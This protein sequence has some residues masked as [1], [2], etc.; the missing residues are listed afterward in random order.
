M[1]VRIEAL[2]RFMDA[3]ACLIVIQCVPVSWITLSAETVL[4]RGHLSRYENCFSGVYPFTG[5]VLRH[6]ELRAR[7]STPILLVEPDHRATE[8]VETV[9]RGTSISARLT[10]LGRVVRIAEHHPATLALVTVPLD[11]HR[12]G[13]RFAGTTSQQMERHS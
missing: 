5:A 6:P 7:L 1:V 8:I 13:G 2:L 3:L 10:Y 11:F 12:S 9:N 4:H